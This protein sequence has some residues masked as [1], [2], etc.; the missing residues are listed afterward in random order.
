[1]MQ[2][3]SNFFPLPFLVVFE[4]AVPWIVWFV[5][6]ATGEQACPPSSALSLCLLDS[7]CSLKARPGSLPSEE[8]FTLAENKDIAVLFS[9]TLL[10]EGQA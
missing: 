2:H 8:V 1:M 4:E 10:S 6:L 9:K 5:N 3:L 7:A